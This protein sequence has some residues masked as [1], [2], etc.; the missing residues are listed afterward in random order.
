M[1]FKKIIYMGGIC[2]FF[3]VVSLLLGS[4]DASGQ[5]PLTI[6]NPDLSMFF[7]ASRPLSASG[8]C[9]PYTWSLSGGGTLTPSGDTATYVAPSSNT[10]CADNAM[11]TLTDQCR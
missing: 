10:D 3:A 5:T 4:G 6:D 9:P 1:R 11:I 8:G 7:N 2:A